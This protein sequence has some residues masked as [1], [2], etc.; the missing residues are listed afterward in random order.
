MLEPVCSLVEGPE[1]ACDVNNNGTRRPGAQAAAVGLLL[2]PMNSIGRVSCQNSGNDCLPK[3]KCMELLSWY[4]Q[5]HNRCTVFAGDPYGQFV[6]H[7]LCWGWP[8]WPC[9]VTWPSRHHEM[10]LFGFSVRTEWTPRLRYPTNLLQL[11]R[12]D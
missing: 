1:A 4:G 12:L 8:V 7:C 10:V 9:H 11:A 3:P 6:V 5:I 2:L